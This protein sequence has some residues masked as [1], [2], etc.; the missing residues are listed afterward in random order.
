MKLNCK[1]IRERYINILSKSEEFF[2]IYDN[3]KSSRSDQI[4][5]ELASIKNDYEQLTHDIN[6]INFSLYEPRSLR[7][8]IKLK[9]YHEV[10]TLETTS[11]EKMSAMCVRDGVVFAGRENGRLDVYEPAGI[12]IFRHKPAKI[13]EYLTP[14]SI[15]LNHKIVS[16][17]A[18]ARDE[19]SVSC[20]QNFSDHY[21]YLFEVSS[22]REDAYKMIMGGKISSN[23]HRILPNKILVSGNNEHIRFYDLNNFEPRKIQSDIVIKDGVNCF[24]VLPDESIVFTGNSGNIGITKKKDD[25]TYS[26]PQII[27]TDIAS[28]FC[29]QVLPNGRIFVG[30]YNGELG[31]YERNEDG[32]YVEKVID[33]GRDY[34]MC[35]HVSP[36]GRVFT[37]HA[38][39]DKGCILVFDPDEFGNYN[40]PSE[41]IETDSPVITLEAVED[42]RVF[43]GLYNGKIKIYDGEPIKENV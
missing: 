18:L 10:Q 30:G 6:I 8:F 32:K 11:V 39:Y 12:D 43:A 3:D 9:N 20:Y 24:Q 40:K 13:N 38:E 37:G 17:Q 16:I 7:D 4:K 36:D 26:K 23:Y 2:K 34:T 19:I 5:K 14:K 21:F 35:L 33:T 1:K 42:G 31:I 41:S 15:D 25:G 27:E 28:I 22:R 29:L